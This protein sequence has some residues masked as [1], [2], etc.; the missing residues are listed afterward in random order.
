M[1]RLSLSKAKA[2][3]GRYVKEVKRGETVVLLER[4]RPVA[5]LVRLEGDELEGGHL[6]EL[7]AA[8]VVKRASRPLARDFIKKHPPVR[9]TASVLAALRD[10]RRGGDR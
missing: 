8:G 4:Q 5:K 9:A 1:K 6:D 7:E 10:D 2:N 3:L